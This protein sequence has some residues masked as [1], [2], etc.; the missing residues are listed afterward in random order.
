MCVCVCVC[1]CV[2]I[3]VFTGSNDLNVF[4]AMGSCQKSLKVNMANPSLKLLKNWLI[5]TSLIL[6]PRTLHLIDFPVWQTP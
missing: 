6:L 1:M 5:T 4:I 2:C 3:S